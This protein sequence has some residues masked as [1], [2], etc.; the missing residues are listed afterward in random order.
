MSPYDPEARYSR[1]RST[2]W[3]GDKTHLT[4]TCD[5]D[6][7]C[8]IP[9][10]ETTSATMPDVEVVDRVHDDLAEHDNLPREHLL[11]RGYMSSDVLVSSQQR[12]VNLIG[13]CVPIPV[14]KRQQKGL[15]TSPSLKL[16]GIAKR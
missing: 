14:G 7:P 6:A 16:T 4:E 3:T 10:V 8:L 13:P 12:D 15:L 11:D 1:K 2:E 9:H 5:Q